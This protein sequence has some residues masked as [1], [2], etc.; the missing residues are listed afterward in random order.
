MRLL[1]VTKGIWMVEM[2][3]AGADSGMMETV[4]GMMWP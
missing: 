2:R 4:T 3:A 1:H